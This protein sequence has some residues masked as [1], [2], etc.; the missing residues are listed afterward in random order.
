MTEKI[1]ININYAN[2]FCVRLSQSV[3]EIQNA[4]EMGN[5]EMTCGKLGNF[6]GILLDDY[7]AKYRW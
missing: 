6:T 7:A 2:C 5:G 1:D 4:G 3:H